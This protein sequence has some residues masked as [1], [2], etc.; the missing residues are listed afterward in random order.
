MDDFAELGIEAVDKVVDKHF[1][2]LPDKAL[3]ANTYHPRNIARSFSKRRHGS[4]RSD[5]SE[6]DEEGVNGRRYRDNGPRGRRDYDNPAA[7]RDGFVDREGDGYIRRSNSPKRYSQ[8]YGQ[9]TYR[10]SSRPLQSRSFESIPRTEAPPT[11]Q[12]TRGDP[13]SPDWNPPSQND[14]RPRKIQAS[15]VYGDNRMQRR[16]GDPPPQRAEDDRDRRRKS[17]DQGSKAPKSTTK[18]APESKK[19][20]LS[21]RGFQGGAVGALLGGLAAHELAAEDRRHDSNDKIAL[22]VL[23]AIAGAVAGKSMG[24]RFATENKS[25]LTRKPRGRDTYDKEYKEGAP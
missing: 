12:Y 1:H 19:S 10:T 13:T 18:F 2:K 4:S 21:D 7:R 14:P 6:S 11:R 17:T 20:V 23:G 24:D 25:M 15:P 9:G 22:A 3:H 8:G 16:N 5:E